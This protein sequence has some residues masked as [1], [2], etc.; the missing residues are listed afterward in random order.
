MMIESLEQLAGVLEAMDVGHRLD[1]PM[2]FSTLWPNPR[3]P[4]KDDWLEPKQRA[5]QWCEHFG[6]TIREMLDPPKLVIE[7]S[8]LTEP[9]FRGFMPAP[10]TIDERTREDLRHFYASTPTGREPSEPEMQGLY[11]HQR[12]AVVVLTAGMDFGAVEMRILAAMSDPGVRTILLDIETD[13]ERGIE[14]PGS[15]DFAAMIERHEI[16]AKEAQAR[17]QPSYLRHD[18]SKRGYGRGRRR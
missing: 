16:R 14:I 13:R 3:Y 11:P 15:Y 5:E 12:E 10:P 2:S 7:K 18:P 9:E 6:C 8:R 1:L 17:P 4:L